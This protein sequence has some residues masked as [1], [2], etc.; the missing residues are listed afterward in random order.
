MQTNVCYK[1]F[2]EM[3][4][5][6]HILHHLLSAKRNT[7]IYQLESL[8]CMNQQSAEPTD[9][10]SVVPYCIIPCTCPVMSLLLFSRVNHVYTL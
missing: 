10:Q 5:P 7:N 8:K 2:T 9:S 4:D 1:L 6:S 3:Y